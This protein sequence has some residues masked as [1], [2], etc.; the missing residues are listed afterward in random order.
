MERIKYFGADDLSVGWYLEKINSRLNILRQK[1]NQNIND[2]L[3]LYNCNI[4]LNKFP[5]YCFQKENRKLLEKT[6]SIIG[7]YFSKINN[8]N[9]IQE[10]EYMNRIYSSDFMFLLNKFKTYKKINEG[11]FV[12]LLSKKLISLRKVCEFKE[13]V[14]NFSRVLYKYMKEDINSS[15]I[16]IDIKLG[17]FKGILPKEITHEIANNLILNY[18]TS[19]KVSY[20]YLL[21]IIDSVSYEGFEIDVKNKQKAKEKI[22]D[23]NEQIFEKKQAIK[24]QYSIEFS[25]INEIMKFDNQGNNLHLYFDEKYLKSNLDYPTIF[26]NFIWLFEFINLNGNLTCILNNKNKQTQIEEVL[27]VQI[28]N[29]YPISHSFRILE[30]VQLLIMRNYYEFLQVNNIEIENAFKWFFEDYV[31]SEF[32]VKN[33]VFSISTSSTYREKCLNLVA[34]IEFLLNQ[35]ECYTLYGEVNLKLIHLSSRMMDFKTL[36]TNITNKYINTTNSV[37]EIYNFFFSCNPLFIDF[38]KSENDGYDN[39]FDLLLD[40]DGVV[41][42]IKESEIVKKIKRLNMLKVDEDQTITLGNVN[43]INLMKILHENN[44]L[45]LYRLSK[46]E[47]EIIETFHKEEL[48]DISSSMFSKLESEMFEFYLNNKSFSNGYSLRNRYAHGNLA[49]LNEKDHYQNY[50]M[51]LRI[52]IMIIL[53]FNDEVCLNKELTAH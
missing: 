17:V 3:E 48:I 25:D 52:T 20:N 31:S 14:A 16:I 37:E 35:I 46:E 36:H 4:Y 40:E 22:E 26:N 8:K 21:K 28:P 11:K 5:N 19:E 51:L 53:K 18:I 30:N 27:S 41:T 12:F 24:F 32:S 29:N 23:I 33:M 10:V 13:I 47:R 42:L 38:I 43:T 1:D 45:L 9:I 44:T 2:V 7:R 49:Y 39:F 15:E 6:N 34:N 50:I